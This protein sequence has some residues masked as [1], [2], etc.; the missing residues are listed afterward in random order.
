MLRLF[1]FILW[2]KD[3]ALLVQTSYSIGLSWA[4]RVLVFSCFLLVKSESRCQKLTSGKEYVKMDGSLI[5]TVL[6]EGRIE[7]I[8]VQEKV[9]KEVFSSLRTNGAQILSSSPMHPSLT[10]FPQAQTVTESSHHQDKLSVRVTEDE[11]IACYRR[12]GIV[13]YVTALGHCVSRPFV[14]SRLD[15]Y[16]Q[17]LPLVQGDL[18]FMY[19]PSL[20]AALDCFL[21]LESS[22]VQA[23][24]VGKRRWNIVFSDNLH[25]NLPEKEVEKSLICLDKIVS[26]SSNSTGSSIEVDLRCKDRYYLK[27]YP[28]TKLQH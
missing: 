3:Q 5:R 6:M 1:F 24:F 15:N 9:T 20:K 17:G 22:L 25:V 27:L 12:N 28:L 23:T 13:S 2:H 7:G 4:I 10:A 8:E 14:G 11:L 26:K 19:F 18:A 16:I 21:T